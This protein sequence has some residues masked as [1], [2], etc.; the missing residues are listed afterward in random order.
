MGFWDTS[1][2]ESAVTNTKEYEQETGGNFDPIPDGSNVLALIDEA[3]WDKTRDNNDGSPVAEFISL[4]WSVEEP[5][6]YA[7]RKIF[8]K[9]FVTD[10]DPKAKDFEKA[11]KKRDKA[12]RMLASIDANCGGK[13][14]RASRKPTDDDLTLALTNKPCVIKV[15]E[16]EFEVQGKTTSGNWV[17]GVFPKNKP[18]SIGESAVKP[19]PKP[20]KAA[21]A[22]FADDLD[23]QDIPF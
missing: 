6:E 1:D 23:D 8:H 11:Q 5:E 21:A 14:S 9:L 12:K 16:W 15:M 10:D 2:G 4:R 17:A 18:I 13:L 19:K 20:A 7:N 3:K 22:S